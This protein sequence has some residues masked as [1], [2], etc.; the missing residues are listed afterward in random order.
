VVKKD[1]TMVEAVLDKSEKNRGF[2]EFLGEIAG[3]YGIKD[4]KRIKKASKAG[5][6]VYNNFQMMT[7]S[8]MH[9][10]KALEYAC[11]GKVFIEERTHEHPISVALISHGYNIYDERASMKVFDKLEQ[12]DTQVFTALQLSDEQTQQ[13]FY[14]A[15]EREMSGAAEFYLKDNRVDGIITI[16]AFGCGPDSLMI[17]RMT[18]RAKRM[19][20]PILNLTIDEQTGEAGFITRLEAFVDMLYRQKRARLMR[21]GAGFGVSGKDVA[22]RRVLDGRDG[23]KGSFGDGV[24]VAKPDFTV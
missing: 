19:S 21:E 4:A 20:K 22:Q 16:N 18:R 6:L 15:N 3:Y 1:F 13:E 7:K 24:D 12:M 17:E 9:Y 5:W 14:W 8:G 11:S 10:D 23:A 2:Y